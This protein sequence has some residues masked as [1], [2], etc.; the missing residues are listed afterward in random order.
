M[1]K[2]QGLTAEAM[3][4]ANAN[5]AVPPIRPPKKSCEFPDSLPSTNRLIGSIPPPL[6]TASAPTTAT[7]KAAAATNG[8]NQPGPAGSLS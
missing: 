8:R 1:A 5:S 4:A 2:P 7:A 6:P 3:P